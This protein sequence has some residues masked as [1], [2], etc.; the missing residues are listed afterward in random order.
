MVSLR[1]CPALAVLVFTAGDV[2]AQ[3][4]RFSDVTARSGLKMP[5]SCKPQAVAVADF[6][7]DGLP[8]VLVATFDEPHV[9]LFR[10]L[11]KLRFKDVTRG[12]GLEAFEGSG[13]GVAVADFDRDGKPDVYLTSVRGG[14]CR[15]FK[16]NGDLTFT[17]VS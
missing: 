5:K 3:P 16:G 15:L 9:R 11:G 1:L 8:D 7:G 12:S 2:A 17:D 6:D 13:S 14:G 10:N 4:L